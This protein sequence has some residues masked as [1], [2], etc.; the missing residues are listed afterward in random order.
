MK[1]VIIAT[2]FFATIVSAQETKTE[3]EPVAAPI[4]AS[5]VDAA[6]ASKKVDAPAT[7]TK[8]AT[9]ASK[10]EEDTGNAAYRSKILE[11]NGRVSDLK[12]KIFRTK[13]RLAILK[14]NV[15]SKTIAGAEGR[16]YHVNNMGASYVLEKVVYSYDGVP[17][18]S[19]IDVDGDLNDKEEIELSTGPLAPGSHTLS[20]MMVYRGNGFG[21]F[22]YLKG[23][24]YTL[25]SSHTFHAEEGKIVTVRTIAYEKGTIT[26]DHRD[27]PDI[28]F[29]TVLSEPAR[30][31]ADKRDG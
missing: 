10:A 3:Q 13:T 31:N 26:T 8:S 19:L 16:F 18:Q 20:V 2:L 30:G 15:L 27:R 28:R 21:V 12:E 14:E 6:P 4:P 29:E 7:A 24:V 9:P 22:S 1:R 25:R 11:L 23:Y 5:E 17:L